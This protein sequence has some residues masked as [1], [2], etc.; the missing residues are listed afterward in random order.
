ME[1]QTKEVTLKN[2]Q[3]AIFRSPV[4]EDAQIFLNFISQIAVQ[5]PFLIMSSED[6]PM[7]LEEET[8]WIENACQS[9]CSAMILCEVDGRLVGNCSISYTPRYKIRHRGQI[10]IA[11]LQ[12]YWGNHIGTLLFEEML[13][14][15]RS[16]NLSQLELT[17]VEGNDRARGLYEKMGFRI[18]GEIPNAI[19]Q[20]DGTMC[21][22]YQMI[23]MLDP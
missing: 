16:W 3:T 2:G 14:I 22:E 15:A 21:K 7:T 18:F 12:E 8:E 11:I 13:S 20:L 17:F 4:P 19:R 6:T 9:P 5:T 10:S 23:R 1:I